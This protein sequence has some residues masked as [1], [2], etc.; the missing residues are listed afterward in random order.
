MQKKEILLFKGDVSRH[1]RFITNGCLKC[2]HIDEAGNEQILQFGIEGWW[3]NDLYSY[4][5]QTP[6]KY[7]IQAIENSSLLQIERNAL[8]KLYNE[9]PAIERFFRIKIQNAYVA[10]QDRTIYS[11][12]KSAK[13][14]YLDFRTSYPNIDQR[15]PQYMVA[16]YLGI[17]PEFLSSI[18]NDITNS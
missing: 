14:R 16:S 2:Y 10:L 11:M 4:L 15:V 8:K 17:T 13:Q 12:S 5:T 9:S 6:A 3:I 1:M 7:F 18:R